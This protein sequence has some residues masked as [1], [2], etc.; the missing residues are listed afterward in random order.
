M[1]PTLGKRKRITRE[2]LE[3]SDRS[4]SPSSQS[5]SSDN[6]DVQDIFR[7][8]FEAKFKPL[9]VEPKMQKLEQPEEASAEEEESDDESNWSGLA[10]SSPSTPIQTISPPS[11]R[12]KTTHLSKSEKRAFMSS[13]PPSNTSRSRAPNPTTTTAA[14]PT[15][16]ATHLKNDL[17]LQRL[18]RDSHL[19]SRTPSSGST[20]TGALRHK[21]TDLHLQTLG[22]RTSI[23]TQK[24]MPMSH[25]KGIVAKAAQREERR[26]AEARENGVILERVGKVGKKREGKREGGVGG[27]GVGRMKGGTLELS[28]RDVRDITGGGGRGGR[29]KGGRRGKR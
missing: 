23:H 24:H 28:R 3:T 1:A 25:R 18:L 4:A 20:L 8:A 17:A 22:A 10:S 14:D 13:K 6:E 5:S 9:G 21:S 15:D 16:E 7:R 29:G 27:P 2:E 11:T 12:P 26:R 19:L